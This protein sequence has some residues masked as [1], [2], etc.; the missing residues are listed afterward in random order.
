MRNMVSMTLA[1]MHAEV[2]TA[3]N[4]REMEQICGRVLFDVVIVLRT[5]PF[6]SGTDVVR[7]LRP[8]GLRKPQM[9]VISWQQS[10]NMVLSL[11]ECGV[12]QYMTFPV[13][14]HRLRMKVADELNRQL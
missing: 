10:E 5:S 6:L 8:K 1:D 14:L 2:R 9:F 7:D 3:K 4:M 13:S 11:L 12:D